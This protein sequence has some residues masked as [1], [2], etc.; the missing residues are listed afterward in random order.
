[1]FLYKTTSVVFKL[2]NLLFKVLIEAIGLD[3]RVV[4]LH[5]VLVEID[6]DCRNVL[7]KFVNP[8]KVE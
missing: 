7:K 3:S 6:K 1:M 4:S 5:L 2:P 8:A